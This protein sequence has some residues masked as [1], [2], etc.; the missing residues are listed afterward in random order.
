LSSELLYHAK[1]S[2]WPPGVPS[3]D[4]K[5]EFVDPVIAAL[6]LDTRID[7]PSVRAGTGTQVRVRSPAGLRLK[8]RTTDERTPLQLAV[9]VVSDLPFG[10]RGRIASGE[11]G[12][13][14]GFRIVPIVQRETIINYTAPEG[15]LGTT[16]VEFVAIH[17]ATPDGRSGAFL[18]SVAVPLVPGVGG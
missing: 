8:D 13:E 1:V 7:A 3:D 17:M 11:P 9:T 12:K 14:T 15:S 5:I 2:I 10:Q 6:P 16:R 18:G 4:T